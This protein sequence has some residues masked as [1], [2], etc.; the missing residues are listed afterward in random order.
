[1]TIIGDSGVGK[2]ALLLRYCDNKY[3]D[4]TPTTIDND[5]RL[6]ELDL[7]GTKMKLQLW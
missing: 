4:T 7:N 3:D 5:Y 6:K 1:M 2:T